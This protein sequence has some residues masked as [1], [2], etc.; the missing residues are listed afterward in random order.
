LVQRG[1]APPTPEEEL[2]ERRTAETLSRRLGAAEPR[3]A[4]ASRSL[5][6]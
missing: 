2:F 4:E 6:P 3:Q 5:L 1:G